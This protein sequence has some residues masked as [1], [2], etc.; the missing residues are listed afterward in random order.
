MSLFEWHDDP[1]GVARKYRSLSRAEW[2]RVGHRLKPDAGNMA[3]TR[4]NADFLEE[5]GEV[6]PLSV[7]HDPYGFVSEYRG[8]RLPVES[9]S[10][11]GVH[12]SSG[13]VGPVC[14]ECRTEFDSEGDYLRLRASSNPALTTYLDQARPIED[15]H[16]LARGLPAVD[17]ESQWREAYEIALRRALLT[18]AIPWADRKNPDLLWRSDA[19]I[20]GSRG[21]LLLLPNRLEYQSRRNSLSAPLDVVRSVVAEGDEVTLQVVGEPEPLVLRIDPETVAV[22]LQSGKRQVVLDASDFA[23]AL[24]SAKERA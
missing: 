13:K 18:G 5:D 6:V 23:N 15:W 21:R 3:C 2:A 11:L 10:Y 16:R 24:L 17:E 20:A 22:D 9:L 14:S 19:E 8:C 7:D 4:C 1:F 12:K